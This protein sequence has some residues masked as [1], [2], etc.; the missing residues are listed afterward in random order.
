[1]GAIDSKHV[2]IRA[3]A[4]SGSQ[5]HNYKHLHSIVL[6]AWV[7]ANYKL[8]FIDVDSNGRAS[9]PMAERVM[10]GFMVM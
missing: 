5:H 3:P 4:Q 9:T 2:A 1:M 6:L 8:I 10:P 7:D